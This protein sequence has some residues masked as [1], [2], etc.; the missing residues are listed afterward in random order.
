MQRR[1]PVPIL[2][3]KL[4]RRFPELVHGMG[5]VHGGLRFGGFARVRAGRER[6]FSALGIQPSDVVLAAQIH[7]KRVRLVDH[8][9]R[10]AGSVPG[11]YI[12]KTDGLVTT[13]AGPVLGV[14]AADCVPVFAYDPIHRVVGI[15]HA[16][17]R[18]VLKSI[19]PVFIKHL[20]SAGAG[21]GSLRIW[22]GPSAHA[23]CYVMGSEH[24][25]HA[26]SF[27]R[28][29]GRSVIRHDAKMSYLDLQR[30]ITLDFLRQGIARSRIEVSPMC[31]IHDWRN[32]PSHRR[33]RDRRHRSL[34]GL[35]G[36]RDSLDHLKG[37]RVLVFGLGL[38]GGGV[39][40]VR[41][42]VR[43]GARV[44]VTDKQTNKALQPAIRELRGL[45]VKFIL[46]RHRKSDI[47]HSDL[48]II[49][50]GV[51]RESPFI[52]EARRLRIPTENDAAIFFRY[53]RSPIIGITGT[54][55]KTT[56]TT[57]IHKMLRAD[58]QRTIA[59]GHN[60]VPLLDALDQLSTSETVIAELSS[61]RLEG[62][63]HRRMSPHIAVITNV[64]PDHLNRY[65]DFKSYL[66]AKETIVAFQGR[67]D[68]VVLNRDT[69]VTRSIGKQARSRRWWFSLQYFAQ[70]NGAFIRNGTV[71][72][73]AYGHLY[74]LF[75][76]DQLQRQRTSSHE[77]QNILAAAIAARIA[78][79]TVAAIRQAAAAFRGIPHRLE[80][81][82]TIDGIRYI[83]DSSA[84][85]PEAA[86]AGMRTVNGRMILIA[87]GSDK[88]LGYRVF[89]RAMSSRCTFVILFDGTATRKLLR[90]I[91]NVPVTVVRDMR[92]AVR[93][94]TA[95][96]DRG[97]TVL[98]SPGA[99]SFGVF[100]HEFDRGDQ[101]RRV[102]EE[103][104][105]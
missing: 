76:L 41:W 20:R 42:L 32:L 6:L 81:V 16:G 70:E 102:I 65:R 27:I 95:L 1:R 75:D 35:I 56:T 94:A 7:G 37:K 30:A 25:K 87:G 59:I 105:R 61:W 104:R 91:V 69:V 10:G 93:L 73:R 43:H 33:E 50:P 23:C 99:A 90:H 98:L 82:G 85:T 48:L 2:T 97:D 14:Y 83:N 77:L 5:I 34:V 28:T 45:P 22:L 54:K 51:P 88:R 71:Y 8:G 24:L 39:S 58:G 67:D 103:L 52:R 44:T 11:R 46:G 29:Y 86:L 74:R 100:K 80:T 47:R 64:M 26:A 78:G 38:H 84:T 15:A 57:L 72:L 17:W 21:S 79:A 63:A 92:R 60:Q 49:N 101:F 19:I 89:G 4:L 36:L 68:H 96:A 31:T 3:S 13:T 12:E 9:D 62:L 55:G 18:G 66:R 53:C 40:T